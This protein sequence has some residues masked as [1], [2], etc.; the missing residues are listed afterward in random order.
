LFFEFPY[1]EAPSPDTETSA[2]KMGSIIGVA[3]GLVIAIFL[4]AV[5]IFV[6]YTS[7]KKNDEGKLYRLHVINTH[8]NISFFNCR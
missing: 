7:K 1:T 2:A 8:F 3:V 5:F 6:Y 4:L